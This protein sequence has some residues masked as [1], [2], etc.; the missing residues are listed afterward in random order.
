MNIMVLRG[1]SALALVLFPFYRGSA[2]HINLRCVGLISWKA[3]LLAW[4]R[5][6]RFQI[7][8]LP[9]FPEQKKDPR[10]RRTEGEGTHRLSQHNE[11]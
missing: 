10:F 4:S 6:R 3:A 8:V 1:N 5:L 11:T 9:R 7:T 2:K